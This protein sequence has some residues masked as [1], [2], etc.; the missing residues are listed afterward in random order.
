MIDWQ[1]LARDVIEGLAAQPA[2]GLDTWAVRPDHLEASLRQVGQLRGKDA[3]EGEERV[4]AR[5]GN[6]INHRS[7]ATQ[8]VRSGWSGLWPIDGAL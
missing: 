8:I 2:N 4:A 3:P 6:Y 5:R 1:A 7:F